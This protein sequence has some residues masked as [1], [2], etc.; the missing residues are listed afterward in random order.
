M[1]TPPFNLPALSRRQS[2][3]IDFKSWQRPVFLVNSRPGLFT[4]SSIS[5]RGQATSPTK[6]PLL[7]KLR[8]E[9]A[10][11]LNRG[12][13]ERLRIL[14]SPTCV[15]FSTVTYLARIRGFSRKHGINHFRQKSPIT[16]QGNDSPDLP[17]ESPYMLGLARPF[18]RMT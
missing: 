11:F 1:L 18:T 14:S 2:L 6:E 13:L 15:S 3:Y 4:A 5:Y 16:S 9:F 8:G 7:P 10:E 12:Y 17:R